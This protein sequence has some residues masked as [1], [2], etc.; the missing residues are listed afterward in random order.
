VLCL[1]EHNLDEAMSLGRQIAEQGSTILRR[2]HAVRLR[3][4]GTHNPRTVGVQD[5]VIA[6]DPTNDGCRSE[7]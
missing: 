4:F 3:S 1:T 2:A 6:I 7:M 5:L